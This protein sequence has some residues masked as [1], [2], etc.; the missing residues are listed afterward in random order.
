MELDLQLYSVR[1]DLAVEAKEIAQG[2]QKTPI[3][4]VNEEVEEAGGIKVT[5]LGVATAAGSQAIGRALGNYVTLEVP[6]CAAGIPGFSRRYRLY[7]PANSSSSL[8]GSASTRIL[9]Y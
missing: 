6:S 3:P 7:S 4:G 5:R 2:P 1:T 9:P 8:P